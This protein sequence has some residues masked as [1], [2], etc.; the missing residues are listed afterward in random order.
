VDNSTVWLL[1]INLDLPL[2]YCIATKFK[3]FTLN[4]IKSY[5]IM[6]IT[7]MAVF[8]VIF[9]TLKGALVVLLAFLSIFSQ[10]MHSKTF[11]QGKK[12]QKNYSVKTELR[13]SKSILIFYRCILSLVF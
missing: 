10:M 6:L 1:L 9:T 2:G 13:D 4:S 11:E 8:L 3:N 5:S 12:H 7:V